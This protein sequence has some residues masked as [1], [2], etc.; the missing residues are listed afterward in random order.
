LTAWK[1]STAMNTAIDI[2]AAYS[3][4]LVEAGQ[5]FS[6]LVV[7]DTDLSDSCMTEGFRKAFPERAVDL[8]IAEQSLP[9]FAAGLALV[10]KIPICNSFAAFSA[11]RGVDMIRQ[12]VA[13]NDANVKI[14]G[15]A[16]GQSMGYTGPS[17]HTL[18]DIAVM[19]AIPNIVILNPCDAVEASQMVW[20]MIEYNGPVYLRLV[21]ATVPNF[22]S[23]DYSFTIG[24]T[25]LLKSGSDITIF[26]TGDLVVLAMELH[27][28]LAKQGCSAQVV[29]VP[30]IKPLLPDEIIQYG[31]ETKAAITI[32]DHNTYGGMGS[33]IAE[34]YSEF[35]FK[36][37]KRIGIKDTFT[38]SDDGSVLRQAYGINLE[39]ALLSLKGI[40]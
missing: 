28:S 8:G 31:K 6:N 7:L 11:L 38:E 32:E 30:T 12:S 10:G 26:V 17:H 34:I 35:L 36:P 13:Y 40:L 14:V 27:S 3:K 16:A 1:K 33:A 29:N 9:T 19:R 25:E 24:K 23:P 37:V 18:E 39:A 21:R 4:T 5:V 2:T 20:K 22:H 15:H